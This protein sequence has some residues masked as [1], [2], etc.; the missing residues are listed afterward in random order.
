MNPKISVIIPTIGRD[1]LKRALDSIINANYK[2]LEII[3]ITD[4][5]KIEKVKKISK[6]IEGIT[7]KIFINKFPLSPAQAKNIGIIESK[8][9]YLTFLDDDDLAYNPKFFSLSEFLDDNSDYFGVFGQYHVYDVEGNLKHKSPSC[10]CDNVCFDTIVK[11]NYIGS[12][13]IMLRNAPEVRF[14]KVPYGFGEDYRL[15][16]DLIGMGKKIKFL[17]IIVYG[18]THNRR[19]G[20]TSKSELNKIVNGQLLWRELVKQNQ[21]EAIKQWRKKLK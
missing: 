6:G 5:S 16:M 8:G 12:G 4:D 3:M 10:G 18:W 14:P 13:S 2:D 7:C 20:F 21:Q 1:S 17:P 15:W 19:D 9:T 11:T